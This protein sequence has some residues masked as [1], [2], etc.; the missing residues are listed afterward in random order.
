VL[1][2]YPGAFAGNTHYNGEKGAQ[3]ISIYASL[4]QHSP[5]SATLQNLSEKWLHGPS[6]GRTKLSNKEQ[7]GM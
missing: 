4:V 6:S 1:A 5:T 7:T 2:R 3:Q